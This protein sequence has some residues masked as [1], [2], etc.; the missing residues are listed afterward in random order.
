MIKASRFILL[1]LLLL[2]AAGYVYSR[3]EIAVP[4]T[5]PLELFPQRVGQWQMIGQARFDERTLEALRPTDYLS[6]TYASGP[7]Q[8]VGFYLGYH[9]G[10]PDSGPI[11][12]PRQCLPGSGWNRLKDEVRT[13]EVGTD[14]VSY[15]SAIY[16]KDIEKQMFLY[17]FQVRGVSL[18]NEYALKLEQ[19]KNSVLYNRRDSAFVRIS[20]AATASEEAAL[21]TGEQFIRDFYP[22]IN[23]TLPQ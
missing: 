22:A 4:I 7:G 17:W 6:R 3:S 19:I 21:R 18:T 12:S 9:N 13:I 8:V 1:F 10:G 5:Q 16:Q 23:R 14:K 20:L 2:G 11:H 15:V